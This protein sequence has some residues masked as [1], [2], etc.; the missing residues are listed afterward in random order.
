MLNPFFVIPIYTVTTLDIGE[1]TYITEKTPTDM[2]LI[3]KVIIKF[4][5]H[6]SVLLIKEKVNNFDNI[7]PFEEIELNE[8]IKGKVL[9]I[10]KRLEL[11]MS[12]QRKF[13]KTVMTHVLDFQIIF[14]V[15]L[16]RQEIL[17][18]NWN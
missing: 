2:E 7:F 5:N 10:L 11:M 3:D 17:L 16:S 9:W 15:T 6:P 14:A 12:F 1:N 4:R 13:L 18:K 8:V